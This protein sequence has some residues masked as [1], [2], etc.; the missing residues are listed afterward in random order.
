MENPHY[1]LPFHSFSKTH[2]VKRDKE[3]Q[4]YY[5]PVHVVDPQPA[6]KT[7][8]APADESS[9]IVESLSRVFTI[10]NGSVLYI[11]AAGI[12]EGDFAVEPFIDYL[13][14]MGHYEIMTSLPPVTGE[15][16]RSVKK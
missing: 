15:R 5:F 8:A 16:C 4:K 6:V 14:T 13:Q 11:D 3:N 10:Q 12:F 2:P 9:N 7:R 1:M